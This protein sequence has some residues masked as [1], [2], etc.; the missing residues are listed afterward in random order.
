MSNVKKVLFLSIY[1]EQE[2][3]FGLTDGGTAYG[4]KLLYP[5]VK[6]KELLSEI[7]FELVNRTQCSPELADAVV[8]IDMNEELLNIFKKLPDN[9]VKVLIAIESPIYSPMSHKGQILSNLRWDKIFTWNRAYNS[10]IISHY[11]IPIAGVQALDNKIKILEDDKNNCGVAVSTYKNDTRG[12]TYF[13]DKLF[14]ELAKLGEL[15]VYGRGW[16]KYFKGKKGILGPTEDKLVSISGYTYSLIIENSFYPGY[17]TEKLG[18]SILAEVPA[19]YYGDHHSASNRFPGTFIK[20]EDI[21]INSF[22]KAKNQLV[23]EYDSLLRAV[24]KQKALSIRWCDSFHSCL[25]SF[26]SNQEK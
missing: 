12:N 14:L 13:R 1:K 21:S 3:N 25:I 22:M 2:G 23:N 6:L 16:K 8:F 11:D 9:I 24:K 4:N 19:I 15:H 20:L 7:N 26:F 18:D 17:V 5:L 10:E